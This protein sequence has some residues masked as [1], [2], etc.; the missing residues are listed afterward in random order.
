[1]AAKRV[2]T[3]WTDEGINQSDTSVLRQKSTEVNAP[4]DKGAK[5]E[6]Q[7]LIDSFTCRYAA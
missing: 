1:M 6:I 7:S 3:L 5:E 2:L 4:F